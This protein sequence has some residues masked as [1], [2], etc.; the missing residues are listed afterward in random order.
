[1][2]NGRPSCRRPCG[3][4]GIHPTASWRRLKR[5]SRSARRL[6]PGGKALTETFAGTEQAPGDPPPEQLGFPSERPRRRSGSLLQMTLGGDGR[7]GKPALSTPVDNSV[8]NLWDAP[9]DAVDGWGNR[10]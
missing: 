5:T 10:M 2:L 8:R 9:P 6:N 7:A 1:M 3:P 4:V